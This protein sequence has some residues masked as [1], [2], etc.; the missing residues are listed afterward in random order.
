VPRREVERRFDEI[1][2]FAE[3][4]AFIDQQ[5]KFY[6][7]GMYTRLGFAIAVSLE[8]DVLLV[9]EVLAVGDESFQ[10]KCIDRVRRFQAEGRTIV[11]VSHAPD[12]VRQICDTA[13]VLE[14]GRQLGDKMP[15][16]D[17]I[18]LF[19]EHLFGTGGGVPGGEIGTPAVPSIRIT[20]I[21]VEHPGGSEREHLL[22]GD[23]LS[24]RVGFLAPAVVDDPVFSILVHDSRGELVFGSDTEVLGQP[25]GPVFGE[26]E[27][28]FHFEA[29]PLLDGT[30][31]ISVGIRGGR[32]GGVYDWRDHEAHFEVVNPGRTL[33]SVALPVRAEVHAGPAPD[34]ASSHA[35]VLPAAPETSSMA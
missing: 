8:P 4:E 25:V 19:R 22:P 17:A 15:P 33:G 35:G 24:V 12:L 34:G 28:V 14:K 1:V 13:I 2:A 7:S 6:S 30:Y 10:R 11:F 21:R 18:R 29:V 31:G 27:V 5:V 16:G 9:D 3:L 32:S 26:G 23:P 20:G